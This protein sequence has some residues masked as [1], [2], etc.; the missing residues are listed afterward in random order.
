MSSPTFEPVSNPFSANDD[1]PSTDGS[2]TLPEEVTA[3]VYCD[4]PATVEVTFENRVTTS[5]SG[6]EKRASKVGAR[7][8][9]LL[10]FEQLTAAD[11]DVL[12]N[13]YLAQ[14]GTLY[15]FSYFDYQSGEEFTVRYAKEVMSREVFVHDAERIGIELVE[16][17]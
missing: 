3:G 13:H 6:V 9:F 1:F 8:R 10:R 12:W 17:L 2:V 4:Y 7:K 16:V 14:S 5:W 15:A 11:A